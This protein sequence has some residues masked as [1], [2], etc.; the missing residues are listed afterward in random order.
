MGNCVWT[1]RQASLNPG[2]WAAPCGSHL[3]HAQLSAPLGAHLH[4]STKHNIWRGEYVDIFSLPLGE[5]V[6]NPWAGCGTVT[7]ELEQFKHPTVERSWHNWLSQYN[8]FMVVIQAQPQRATAP[9]KD[10]DT[11]HRAYSSVFSSAWFKYDEM[12]CM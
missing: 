2:T 9:I 1:S 3:P 12:C 7:N 6:L 8:I 10:L 11:V 4:P 5:T